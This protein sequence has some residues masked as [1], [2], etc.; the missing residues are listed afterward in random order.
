M[1]HLI[2]HPKFIIIIF[3]LWITY[4][5]DE[6]LFTGDVNCDECYSKKPDSIDIVLHVTINNS[7]NSIVPVLIYKDDITSGQFIDTIFCSNSSN[8]VFVEADNNYSAKAIYQSSERIVYVV[9][10]IKQK[11]KSVTGACTD[12]ESCW[13]VENTDL[14]LELVY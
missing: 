11:L 1:V 8:P 7:T 5:C 13:I 12:K 6:K 14:Y 2:K 4:A 9:D 10:G 3:V